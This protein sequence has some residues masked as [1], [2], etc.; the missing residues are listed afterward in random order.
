MKFFTRANLSLK[1][2]LFKTSLLFCLIFLLGVLM[3]GAVSI[4]AAIVNTDRG[5][6]QQLPAIVTIHLDGQRLNEERE[7]RDEWIYFDTIPPALIREIGEFPY[8][9][10]F[11]YTAWGYHFFSERLIRA[12]N[13]DL[14]LLIDHPQENLRDHGSFRAREEVAFEQ[15]TLK[16]IH[17]PNVVDIESGLVE[18]I[19][20]RVFTAAEV[21]SGENVAIVSH[22]FLK[23]N[24]LSLGDDLILEYRIYDEFSGRNPLDYLLATQEFM[25]EIIG[26]FEHRLPED[27]TLSVGAIHQHINLVNQLYVP[28]RLIESTLDLYFDTFLETDPEVLGEFLGEESIEDVIRYENI[29]FL[30]NDPLDLQPFRDHVNGLLPEFW[31]TS[32]LSSAY[33]DIASSMGMMLEIA[34]AL[35]ISAFVATLLTLGLLILICLKERN[36]EIGIY[37]A[38]GEKREKIIGQ[39]LIEIFIVA[40]LALSLSLVAGHFLATELS[41]HMIQNDLLR[42]STEERVTIIEA[43]TP[44]ALGFR[45]EMTHEEMFELYDTSLD[46]TTVFI[47]YGITYVIIFISVIPP[48]YYLVKLQPKNILLKGRIG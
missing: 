39:I 22:P 29:I 34:D 14:F 30:L 28:N 37:L 3:S 32:D 38:L 44:E 43:D 16:G 35:A 19:S 45:H 17:N 2:Q 42:Q 10:S 11:D 8:V 7:L 25:L 24:N 1:R 41:T 27:E 47:F 9:R 48:I 21:E 5:L 18:L 23:A 4:R 12:F 26:V 31:T 15:F 13:E 36:L 40:T 6:R 46:L 33:A 20:G